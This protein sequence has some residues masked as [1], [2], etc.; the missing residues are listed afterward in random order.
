MNINHSL[1]EVGSIIR[2][3]DTYDKA[4]RVHYILDRLNPPVPHRTM[5]KQS[6]RYPGRTM[7][8]ICSDGYILSQE[9]IGVIN[10]I[11]DADLGAQEKH[12]LK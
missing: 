9:D 6:K 5:T 4:Y 7:Y 1:K 2:V 8:A 10:H 12:L 11:I 3:V